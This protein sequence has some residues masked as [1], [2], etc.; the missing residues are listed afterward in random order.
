MRAEGGGVDVDGVAA[1]RLD[2]LDARR[3]QVLAQVGDAAQA[4]LQVVLVEHL[5]EA[6]RHRFEVAAGQAAVGDESL[7]QDQ[8]VV[9][10]AGPGRRRASA[11]RRRC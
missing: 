11:A 6:L 4:V 8:Q 10:R 2:D 3:Q 9:R 1:R 5:D 7:G